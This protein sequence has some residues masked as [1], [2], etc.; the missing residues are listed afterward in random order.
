MTTCTRN[1]SNYFDFFAMKK[2]YFFSAFTLCIFTQDKSSVK[3]KM[4]LNFPE[5][6]EKMIQRY[7][8]NMSNALNIQQKISRLHVIFVGSMIDIHVIFY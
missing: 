7:F 8:I 2:I 3:Y 6:L 5:I 1:I 4:V